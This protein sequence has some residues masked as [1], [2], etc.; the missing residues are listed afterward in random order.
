M[1]ETGNIS[2]KKNLDIAPKR[3]PKKETEYLSIAAQN[4]AIKT[5]YI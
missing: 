3:K 5:N 1:R 2:Q 4:D